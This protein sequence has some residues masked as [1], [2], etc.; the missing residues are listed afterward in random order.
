MLVMFVVVASKIQQPT[1]V[2]PSVMVLKKLVKRLYAEPASF[3]EVLEALAKQVEALLAP[4]RGRS[5]DTFYSFLP[6][7]PYLLSSAFT[8][9]NVRHGWQKAGCAPFKAD[10]ILGRC[11]RGGGAGDRTRQAAQLDP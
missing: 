10:A 3:P 11:A 6:P 4:I 2:S 9:S 5:Y 7:P 1:D 8:V